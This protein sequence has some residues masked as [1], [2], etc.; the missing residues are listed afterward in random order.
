MCCEAPPNHYLVVV[1]HG[2]FH[3]ERSVSLILTPPNAFFAVVPENEWR[4]VC[5]QEF[6]PLWDRPVKTIFTPLHPVSAIR[7]ADKGL[8]DLPVRIEFAGLFYS[9]PD[10]ILV[11]L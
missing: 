8:P 5:P 9:I 6:S 3:R 10:C 7:L 4:L 11:A 1:L 2:P